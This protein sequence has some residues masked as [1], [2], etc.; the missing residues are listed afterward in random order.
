MSAQDDAKNSERVYDSPSKKYRL[1]VTSYKTGPGTWNCTK[2]DIFVL[3]EEGPVWLC[4]VH[5]NYESFWH[6]WVEGHVSNG[7]DY[8]LGTRFL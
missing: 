2:G 7:N 3:T 8:L 6:T 5:R 4:D 1:V